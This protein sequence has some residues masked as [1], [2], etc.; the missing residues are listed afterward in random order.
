[1]GKAQRTM[2]NKNGFITFF[3]LWLGLIVV[4]LAITTSYLSHLCL[5]QACRYWDMVTAAYLA[6]SA[7]VQS[8]EELQLM[9]WQDIPNRR[10]KTWEDPYHLTDDGQMMRVRYV[11]EKRQKP[12]RGTV[13]AVGTVK[14]TMVSRTCSLTYDIE[15]M[16]DKRPV[17]TIRN[18]SY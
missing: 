3:I 1:M 15:V 6:E 16:E 8:W 7:L 17:L 18:I 5:Q 14:R 11:T 10:E 2:Q 9:D 4:F 13:T 12:Y